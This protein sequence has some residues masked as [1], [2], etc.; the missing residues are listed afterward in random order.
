MS[1][2]GG[3]PHPTVPL[4]DVQVS[5]TSLAAELEAAVREVVQSGRYL[6]GPQVEQ[7]EA[8]V[9]R[10]CGVEQAIACASGSDALLLSL[11]ALD[12]GPG[13]EVIVPAF[14]FFATASAAWRLGAKPVF[15]DV[16]AESFTLDP[17]RVAEAIS[18]KT[19]AIIP[20]HL[21]GRCARMPELVALASQ[22]GISL[23]EDAAQAIGADYQG[24]HAGAWGTFGCF[25]FYPTKNLGGC[26][27]G[28]MITTSD[29]SLAA[30]IRIL[31]NHGMNPRYVHRH[32]G[33]NSRLDTIQAAILLVKLARL[34]GWTRARKQHAAYYTQRFAEAGL[35]D[36]LHLPPDD[37]HG[38]HV[39]NQYT[40]RVPAGQRDSLRQWLAQRG[41]GTEIYYP[42]P[43]HLQ[44]CFRSLGYQPG[45]LPVC[46]MLASE[47]LSLPVYPE[48]TESQQDYIVEQIGRFARGQQQ[49]AA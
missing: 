46:E 42:I 21:F 33:I 8:A 19:R 15:V 35:T 1:G 2:H 41:I 38:T 34:D 17:D 47:V 45:D 5:N 23:V 26:G 11:M 22:H 37:P 31:A 4:V 6:F 25:S 20:V 30:K 44:P 32:V 43:L 24:R 27:D 12:I 9:A 16:D 29:R 14:T 39:W 28:G 18:A 13:D 7:L 40:I 49:A 3:P 10:L 48:L 36:W